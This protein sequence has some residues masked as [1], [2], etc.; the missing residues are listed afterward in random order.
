MPPWFLRVVCIVRPGIDPVCLWVSV[1]LKDFNDSF[2]NCFPLMD[3]FYGYALQMRSLSPVQMADYVSQ[4]LDVAH[5]AASTS[6]PTLQKSFSIPAAIAGVMRSV[7]Y[8][9]TKL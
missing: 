6:W 5:D 2:P 3:F 8:L 9:L 7:M 4:L 1:Q